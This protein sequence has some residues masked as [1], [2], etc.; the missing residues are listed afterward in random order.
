MGRRECWVKILSNRMLS[1]AI[2]WYARHLLQGNWTA[3][4]DCDRKLFP[5]LKELESRGD[6]LLVLSFSVPYLTWKKSHIERVKAK[7]WCPDL[8]SWLSDDRWSA[9]VFEMEPVVSQNTF[10]EN[11]ENGRSPSRV[12]FT[13]LIFKY[14]QESWESQPRSRST[15]H[16]RFLRLFC[17]FRFSIIFF[18]FEHPMLKRTEMREKLQCLRIPGLANCN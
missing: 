10:K 4:S 8:F 16:A 5:A 15:N 6:N 9:S 14:F 11:F 7:F 17:C 12:C 13:A 1:V 2:F 3:K 18:L